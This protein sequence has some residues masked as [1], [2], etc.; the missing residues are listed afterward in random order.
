MLRLVAAVLHLNPWTAVHVGFTDGY[1]NLTAS[2]SPDGRL[3]R[4]QSGLFS[5]GRQFLVKASCLLRF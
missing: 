5:T 2:Q 1:E 4:T 3:R